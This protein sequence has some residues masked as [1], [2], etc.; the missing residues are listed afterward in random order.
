MK[1]YTKTGDMGTTSLIGGRRVP[2]YHLR[3]D[4]YGTID[5]LISYIGLIRSPEID[6]A[7]R[8][9]LLA[10]Q[11]RLMVCAAI[12]ATDCEDCKVKIPELQDIDIE[13]LE[14]EIDIMEAELPQ[15]NSFLLLGGHYVV[16]YCNVAR[17]VCR[18][19]ERIIIHLSEKLFVPE[20][21]LKYI[22]RLSDYL[23]VLSRK[24]GK[25]L[26]IEEI[27]WHSRL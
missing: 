9:N 1:I 21:L 17:T 27:Q 13:A 7:I 25:D 22:N 3:I 11:D 6:I 20:N 16:A 5:E 15:L 23:F 10:I 8:N 14:K 12:L 19:A 2:K 4:A 18:R 26:N 24:L